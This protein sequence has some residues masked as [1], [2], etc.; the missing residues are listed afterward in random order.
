MKFP[1]RHGL[2]MPS[3][4]FSLKAKSDA[5][6]ANDWSLSD[7]NWVAGIMD[8]CFFSTVSMHA[9]LRPVRYWWI[10]VHELTWANIREIRTTQLTMNSVA[11]SQAATWDAVYQ[12][13][14]LWGHYYCNW[15]I[16][17]CITIIGNW[18]I[19]IIIIIVVVSC[20]VPSL[21]WFWWVVVLLCFLTIVSSL[22]SHFMI[23]GMVTQMSYLITWE[24]CHPG[25]Q[26]SLEVL[27]VD[28]GNATS[29]ARSSEANWKEF[30]NGWQ[31]VA[32]FSVV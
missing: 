30:D 16:S 32:A 24:L 14:L 10:S 26:R 5:A 21:V 28:F 13:L 6:A 19:S 7:C 20:C 11:F 3:W 15:C 9:E 2:L 12:S 17:D 4:V 22:V 18:S 23:D 29:A 31:V 8:S 25:C 1:A 27:S